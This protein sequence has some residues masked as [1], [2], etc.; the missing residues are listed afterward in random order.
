MSDWSTYVSLHWKQ[1]R[2][3]GRWLWI[4][5]FWLFWLF[6]GSY[7]FSV[8]LESIW[9]TV[10]TCLSW[11]VGLKPGALSSKEQ[12][13]HTVTSLF[14]LTS[15]LN[16]LIHS[17]YII[18]F[19][20]CV[21]YSSKYMSEPTKFLL[22]QNVLSNRFRQLIKSADLNSSYILGGCIEHEE[23]ERE[24]CKDGFLFAIERSRE[25][26]LEVVLQYRNA[27]SEEASHKDGDEKEYSRQKAL[28]IVTTLG[29][30]L[31]TLF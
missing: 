5:T 31:F 3:K 13:L 26:F 6:S 23:E 30:L 28:K 21:K 25:I 15:C 14:L 19:L 8:S 1:C 11:R 18:N 2:F 16:S 4:W 17:T 10:R 22:L 27:W 29:C 20:L 9:V 24:K 7:L 12:A